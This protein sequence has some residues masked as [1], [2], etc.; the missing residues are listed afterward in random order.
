M[1]PFKVQRRW[2]VTYQYGLDGMKRE[3]NLPNAALSILVLIL[4]GVFGLAGLYL[5][6]V[7]DLGQTNQNL[8]KMQKEN[9]QLRH[10]LDYYSGI[11]DSIYLKLD[12]MDMLKKKSSSADRYYPYYQSGK[13]SPITDNTFVY[14]SYLDARVNALEQQIRQIAVN[15]N[16]TDYSAVV[17]G[18]S[19][20]AD[21]LPTDN[22]PSI[23][24]T[25]GRWSDGWGTRLHPFS[26]CLAFHYGIDISNKMGTPIYATADGEVSFIGYDPEYGKL[27]KI[28]HKHDFETRYGHLYSFRV[29]QGDVVR[30]GQIIALM[31]SSGIST[32]PH[33][34]YE[35]LI[36]GSKVNPSRYLNRSDE[37]VYYAKK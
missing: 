18:S 26:H 27:I 12:S 1:N 20:A 11:V 17:A 22:G 7:R 14:D 9:L 5:F 35:V 30:K 15:T 29:A 23:F 16:L 8:A 31:G 34:H 10:K 36:A 32:G 33:L 24:P 37:P 13:G 28:S 6:N 19:E 4:I 2:K 21:L 3:L 25:F